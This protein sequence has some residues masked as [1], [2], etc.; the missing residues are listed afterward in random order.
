MADFLLE[1]DRPERRRP[2]RLVA[3]GLADTAEVPRSTRAEPAPCYVPCEAC[4][5]A[6]L[7][8]TTSAGVRLA[9]DTQVP[10]YT[11][12]W[13]AGTP[14]PVLQGSRAYPVHHC[15]QGQ[16]GLTHALD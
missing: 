15:R 4:G 7:H 13:P 11:V 6:V 8:G 5:Q 1:P 3:T 14:E 16:E 10:T 12:V 9:L 2:V